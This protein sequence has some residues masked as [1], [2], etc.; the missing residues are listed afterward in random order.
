MCALRILRQL[1]DLSQRGVGAGIG[2]RHARNSAGCSLDAGTFT[3]FC[4]VLHLAGVASFM[5][6]TFPWGGV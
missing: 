5:P 3:V 4:P 6:C 2:G 1:P